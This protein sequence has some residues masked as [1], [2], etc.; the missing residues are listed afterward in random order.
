DSPAID[1][2]N[3][4]LVPDGVTTD[5]RGF[6]RITGQRVDIGAFEV[7]QP[8]TAPSVALANTATSLAEDTD[9]TSAVKVA[10]IEVTDDVLGTNELSLSGDDAD[11]FEIVGTELFPKAGTSLDFETNS[12][13]DVTVNVHDATLGDTPDSSD[14]LTISVTNVN[15]RPTNITLEGTTVE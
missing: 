3:S 9:T 5:Q 13:L 2:G 8:N 12:S 1:A 14:A 11:L 6:T 4:S 15:E 10:D 7:Q